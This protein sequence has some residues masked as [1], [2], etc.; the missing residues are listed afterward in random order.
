MA[1]RCKEPSCFPDEIGCNVEGCSNVKDCKNYISEE[2]TTE[3][4]E[5]VDEDNYYRIPWTGNSFGLT[6]LNYLTASS[7]PIFIGITGVASAGK[8]TFL[9][10][11][12]CLL[13][14]GESIG[15]YSFAG[16]L[17]L[18][19]WEN[20]AWYLSWKNNGNIQFPPHTSNNA[21]RLPGLLH[22][23]LKN[24]EGEKIDLVF[25][26]APGEWFDHWRINVNNENAKGA[27]WIHDNC[28]A[29]LLF[30]DCE[31]LTPTNSKR[32]IAK[33]QINS[34]A[35]RIMENL[36]N[37]PFELIWS[38]SDI[39]IPVETK[40][41]IRSHFKQN[42]IKYFAEYET[43][44]KAGEDELFHQN[45]CNSI[46][47]LIEKL[48]NNKNQIPRILSHK[49]EDMFLSKRAINE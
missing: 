45:I 49:P 44:V 18:I 27:K 9:A 48:H 13:R 46:D 22:I 28:D 10:S 23:A 41:Q 26:D 47:W 6:D 11:L 3:D 24:N 31:M 43:S 5:K 37:R 21:G 25:T 1:G 36:G 42:Q 19:G 35:D 32:G 8:T 39:T 38:K 17:T 16:S 33:Q 2:S 34:V 29:F 4:V 12:Y 15:N 7:K 40:N 30:A 14:N 20:I